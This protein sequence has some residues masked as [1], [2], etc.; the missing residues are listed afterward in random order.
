ME[1]ETIAN[2]AY[3]ALAE[4]YAARIDT[5]AHN[6]Y[7]ERPATWSLLDPVAGKR[8][9]DAGC[10][11]G[12]YAE[13][14]LDAGAE[15]VA[16][17]AN[18]RMLEMAR[19]RLG[20]RP[21]Q[22]IQANLERKLDFLEAE[23][24]DGVVCALVLDYVYD[25]HAVFAEFQRV[26]KPNGAV[27]FSVTHPFVDYIEHRRGANYFAVEQVAYL[28]RGFGVE[29]EVPSYRRSFGDLLTP[30]LATGFALEA[31]LEPRPQPE[32][33]AADPEEYAKLM[34]RPG[35]ICL[36]ARRR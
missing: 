23:S 19:R 27:V 7:Y 4:G 22:L 9:L 34:V 26:L 30:L 31:V 3:D 35:F 1:S 29:V 11:V 15:V 36:K 8:I 21:V 20:S 6:A 28:W 10:G 25:W 14:L 17:D 13:M 12:K 32:F 24:F 18:A 33:W 2:A 5:K 16:V